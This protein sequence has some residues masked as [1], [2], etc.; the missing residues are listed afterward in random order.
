MNHRFAYLEEIPAILS[1][2][3]DRA[4][5]FYSD[6]VELATHSL[7]FSNA[8]YASLCRWLG[9]WCRRWRAVFPYAKDWRI[10]GLGMVVF[11]CVLKGQK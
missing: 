9:R 11:V 10:T 8:I 5:V 2:V 6:F 1:V 3:G 4:F 7:K